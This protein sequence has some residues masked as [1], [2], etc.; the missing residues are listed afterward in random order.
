MVLPTET[1]ILAIIWYYLVLYGYYWIWI[2]IKN[3]DPCLGARR[4]TKFINKHEF[5][6]FKKLI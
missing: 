2:H 6:P 3:A 4:L 5:Q 1:N